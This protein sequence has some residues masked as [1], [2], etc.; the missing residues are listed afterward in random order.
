MGLFKTSS[1]YSAD[2]GRYSAMKYRR[3]GRS[4]VLLPEVSLGFWQ[5]FSSNDDYGNCRS[6]VFDAFDR[7]V[8][9]F[10]LADNYGG[11]TSQDVF[12]RILHNDLYKYRD[13]LFI[14]TKAGY[15]MWAGPYGEW[16]SR[17]HL[18]ASLDMSLR[19]MKLDYVDVFYSH[20]PD[21]DTPLEETMDALASVV[22]AGKALYV[23]ISNYPADMAGRAV[24]ILSGMGV[25]CLVH[26][27]KY[28]M[29][30]RDPENGLLD[31]LG[32]KGVGMVAFQSLGQGLLTGRYLNGI[33]EDS[34]ILKG[35]GSITRD[36]VTE[37]LM[38]RLG[39]LDMIAR[40]RGQTLAQL[41]LSWVLRDERVASVIVGASSI[42]Q[43]EDSLAAVAGAPLCPEELSEIETILL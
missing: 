4:G 10:D 1:M 21:Y 23:G 26:Q 33:P 20:R 17:K 29:L 9:H 2:E 37:S 41:A 36:D 38:A 3:C 14:S 22:R 16:G 32:S 43:L 35:M 42:K 12:G 24:D 15:D 27:A 19:R 13:E 5:H 11:G 8:T 39:Q 18:I 34:R 7:G 30:D 6:I 28:S 40:R 31:V 25:K